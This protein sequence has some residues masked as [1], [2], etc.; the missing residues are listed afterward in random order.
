MTME[1]VNRIEIRSHETT[2]P[3]LMETNSS[4]F[5]WGLCG[6][7]VYVSQNRVWFENTKC[8]D[9]AFKLRQLRSRE[10]E[11]R[12]YASVVLVFPKEKKIQP[13]EYPTRIY[14]TRSVR[15]NAIIYASYLS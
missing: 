7:N 5:G 4:K 12:W 14:Q 3:N 8:F 11:Q 15:R 10:F 1:N 6:L 2:F 13:L 9:L